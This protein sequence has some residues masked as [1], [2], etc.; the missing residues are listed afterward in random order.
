MLSSNLC[1]IEWATTSGPIGS[2]ENGNENGNRVIISRMGPIISPPKRSL[3]NMPNLLLV[4]GRT[5][6][7]AWER[8]LLACRDGGTKIRT[9]YDV[10]P[11]TGTQFPPSLD[12]TMTMV[13]D[14]VVSEPRLHVCLIGGPNE[15]GDYAAEV[16]DG[17]RDHWIKRRPEDT[18]WAYTYSGRLHRY[19]DRLNA[20]VPESIFD[21]G[22][23]DPMNPWIGLAFVRDIV[24][25][26][27][28]KGKVYLDV[29]PVDQIARMVDMLV[30]E[31]YTRRAV[32]ETSFPPIDMAIDD[33]PCLR[34][35]WCRGFQDGDDGELRI[36]MNTHW[37]SRDGWKAA[38]FNIFGMSELLADI[39]RRV[40]AGLDSRVNDLAKGLCPRCG[41]GMG[42]TSVGGDGASPASELVCQ[43]CHSH[44][45]TVQ[46]GIYTDISD[47][48]HIYGK[49]LE[50]FEATLVEAVRKRQPED[51]WWDLKAKNMAGMIQ[52]GKASAAEMVRHRDE[53]DGRTDAHRDDDAE[54]YRV[55]IE[56][57]F[58]GQEE[59][60]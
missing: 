15:L 18:E 39:V 56:I 51:R 27:G 53:R 46:P 19:G 12:C 22:A 6:P 58:D 38:P 60:Q 36:H 7:E 25:E 40:Q 54:D 34:Y 44:A 31:P 10:D 26:G 11:N 57:T 29:R 17:I 4:Q 13:I 35:I 28:K 21:A 3:R 33:P 47:S 16:V 14:Q 50:N 41:S 1:T 52:D 55:P 37:R 42:F 48:Y 20:A 49:D 2:F 5:A 43:N 30:H 24:W 9:Q 59:S 8:S 32:A 45:F 23:D